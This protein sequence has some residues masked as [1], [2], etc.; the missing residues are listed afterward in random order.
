MKTL[1]LQLSRAA[2]LIFLLCMLFVGAWFA[3]ENTAPIAP[4][5]FGFVLPQF[6]SGLYLISVLTL[7]V[8]I[9]FCLS[10]AVNMIG[11][12]KSRRRLADSEKKIKRL[13]G[14][15]GGKGA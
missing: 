5:L 9:G 10:S 13:Q 7:G 1:M 8:L 2:L 4:V 12:L 11:A 3:N 6:S 15:V 14:Q